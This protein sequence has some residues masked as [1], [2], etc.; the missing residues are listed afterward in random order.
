MMSTYGATKREID[1]EWTMSFMFMML[2]QI[3]HQSSRE[4]SAFKDAGGGTD[5]SSDYSG[6]SNP[7]VSMP[8]D[9]LAMVAG[10]PSP[11]PLASERVKMEQSG[12]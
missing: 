8:A 9:Q 2:D 5:S 11:F 12:Q 10:P 3:K 7:L 4:A 1:E 6:S